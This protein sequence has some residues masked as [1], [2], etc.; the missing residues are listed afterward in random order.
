MSGVRR[1]LARLARNTRRPSTAA[2]EDAKSQHYP[3][4]EQVEKILLAVG[5]QGKCE[6]PALESLVKLPEEDLK[7]A[8]AAA[9]L[10]G[11]IEIHDI[12]GGWL[13]Y[14]SY[15]PCVR[16]RGLLRLSA[17]GEAYLVARKRDQIAGTTAGDEVP[18]TGG[19]AP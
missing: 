8:V 19:I 7:N 11:L 13:S 4:D 9:S 3:T 12:S 2:G 10:E 16:R 14:L 6:V 1:L 5:S 17:K 15:L 18:P